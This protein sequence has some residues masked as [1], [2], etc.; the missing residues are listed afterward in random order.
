MIQSDLLPPVI[1]AKSKRKK[2]LDGRYL[3]VMIIRS[4]DKGIVYKGINFKKIFN[5]EW[6]L[7]KQGRKNSCADASG[8]DIHDRFL[9]QQS[10]NKSLGDVIPMPTVTDCFIENEEM[11]LV[12]QFIEGRSLNELIE[13]VFLNNKNISVPDQDLLLKHLLTISKNLARLHSCGYVHRDLSPENFIISKKNELL[14][15]DLELAYC[16]SK[17]E[18]DPPFVWGTAGFM[19]PAQL[20]CAPPTFPDDIYGL[21]ALLAY[22]LTGIAPAD[23][24]LPELNHPEDIL[25]RFMGSKSLTRII[26]ACLDPNPHLRP[27]LDLIIRELRSCQNPSA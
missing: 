16:I 17:N 24:G 1:T 19:S 15:I 27:D 5:P 21:G 14:F 3:P 2:F 13:C 8:R 25:I 10:L 18:P 4:A 9:W 12:M 23:L 26:L 7:I 22:T 6:C 11:F 20:N